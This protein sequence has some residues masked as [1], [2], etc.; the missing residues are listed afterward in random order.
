M[1]K[2]AANDVANKAATI[3]RENR[4]TC[5]GTLA[6]PGLL[7]GRYRGTVI[8]KGYCIVDGGTTRVDGNLVLRPGSAV[9]ATYARN[10]VSGSGRSRLWVKGNVKVYKGATLLMG[11]EPKYAPCT[12]DP[13][14]ATGGK[15]RERDTVGGS[16]IASWARGVDVFDSRIRGN[17]RQGFGGGGVSCAVPPSGVF[18]LIHAHVSSAYED[19]M[20]AGSLTVVHVRTCWFGAL[21]DRVRGSLF[22]VRSTLADGDGSQV[23]SN[24]VHRA[25][26]CIRRQTG[27]PVRRFG[28][29]AQPGHAG[30]RSVRFQAPTA[31]SGSQRTGHGHLRPKILTATSGHRTL[32]RLV[33]TSLLG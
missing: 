29:D 5:T 24:V 26:H 15:L 31:Q 27:G 1:A 18:S 19:D 13:N 16:L 10:D 14:A 28:W 20:I 12:D 3:R 33:R 21:R 7:A 32:L 11:C 9:N 8:V 17:V 2:G 23:V 6:T 25:L 22:Y 4:R 30:L